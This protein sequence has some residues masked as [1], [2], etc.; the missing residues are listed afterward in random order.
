MLMDTC[1]LIGYMGIVLLVDLT[2]GFWSWTLTHCDSHL[3]EGSSNHRC[4]LPGNR[5]SDASRNVYIKQFTSTQP[6][7][8]NP[9]HLCT[10]SIFLFCSSPRWESLSFFVPKE[11]GRLELCS[12]KNLHDRQS[13]RYSDS[14]NANMHTIY[15]STSWK[16]L[17]N[18][19]IR[20][21][22][23]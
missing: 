19:T 9:C 6:S 13:W 1:R 16:Y 15:N 17:S 11:V 3:R 18:R 4:T 20:H 8:R 7:R 12:I 22:T 5:V 21:C 14:L 2:N 23:I 10:P